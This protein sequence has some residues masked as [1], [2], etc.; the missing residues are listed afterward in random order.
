MNLP[1]TV[2]I[3]SRKYKVEMEERLI[4]EDNA[5]RLAG[6]INHNQLTIKLD[7]DR[8]DDAIREVLLHE[9][10]HGVLDANAD[11]PEEVFVMRT[12]TLLSTVML[13][14]PEMMALWR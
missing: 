3:G 4:G 11:D 1:K 5:T 14:N 6:E 12:A 9:V 2:K 7:P 13:D 10:L 8:A